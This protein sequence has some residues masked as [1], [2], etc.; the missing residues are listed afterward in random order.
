MATVSVHEAKTHLSRL[1]AAVLAG[2]EVTITR[3]REPVVKIVPLEPI[4]KPKRVG[5][6]LAHTITPGKDPLADG[7]WDPLPDE[8]LRLWNGESLPTDPLYRPDD[9][10]AAT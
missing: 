3:G 8:E 10:A 5:G 9:D 7:F 2:E 6:W 1:I 4:A